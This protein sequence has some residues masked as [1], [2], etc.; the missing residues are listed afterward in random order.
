MKLTQKQKKIATVAGVVATVGL[1]YLAFRK[2]P[3]SG[4]SQFD[5][6]NNN[7][8]TG[9]GG[10]GSQTTNTAFNAR[11][12]AETLYEAMKG[13]GTDE[14]AIFNA[15]ATVTEPQFKQVIDAFGLRI[16]N[17]FTGSTTWG[18]PHP[19]KTW[20]KEELGSKEYGVL[21]LKYPNYL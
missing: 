15:L 8:S 3:D 21:R 10:G 16:Y 5:P 14:S 19:L 2:K 12:V 20:L 7:I 11:N 18:S 17:T 9:T 4:G 6:T 1:L 13:L